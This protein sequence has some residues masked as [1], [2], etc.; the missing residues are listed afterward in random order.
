MCP[1]QPSEDKYNK[2]VHISTSAMHV[3]DVKLEVR[4]VMTHL[5]MPV[6]SL[7]LVTVLMVCYDAQFSFEHPLLLEHS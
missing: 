6:F 7:M 4:L 3:I 1:Y 5:L 2:T